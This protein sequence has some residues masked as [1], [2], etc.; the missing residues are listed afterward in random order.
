MA[1]KHLTAIR[2]LHHI[3]DSPLIIR[4]GIHLI[5][6]FCGFI[7]GIE[8][9]VL[10]FMERILSE[11]II[12]AADVGVMKFLFS[13]VQRP[14]VILYVI[15]I[16]DDKLYAILVFQII[17]LLLLI[18]EDDCNV[19]DSSLLQLFDLPL[20]KTLA[21]DFIEAFRLFQ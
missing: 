13:Q 5:L 16:I 17:K 12:T 18:A 21:F 20:D 6:L 2:T 7:T 4:H 11:V 8:R 15:V 1:E 14:D 3:K 9:C 10:I 19:I